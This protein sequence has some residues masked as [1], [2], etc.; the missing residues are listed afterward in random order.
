[1]S[2]EKGR[3]FGAKVG[4]CRRIPTLYRYFLNSRILEGLGSLVEGAHHLD[5][6]VNCV[7]VLT[8]SALS[9][10]QAAE[11]RAL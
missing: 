6:A 8:K 2:L 4:I 1:M 5:W 11:C 7:V 9:G 10:I 3:L